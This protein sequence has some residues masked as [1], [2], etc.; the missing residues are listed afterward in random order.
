M[1]DMAKSLTDRATIQKLIEKSV[2]G[3]GEAAKGGLTVELVS[4]WFTE[5][6]RRHIPSTEHVERLLL[7]L[8]DLRNSQP[9]WRMRRRHKFT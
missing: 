9:A 7:L 8:W 6:T 3:V 4:G 2:R 1:T 5:A